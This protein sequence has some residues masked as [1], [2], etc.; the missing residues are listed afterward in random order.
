MQDYSARHDP[1]E[2]QVVRKWRIGM[3]AF[4]GSIVATLLLLSAIADRPVQLAGNTDR[5]TA[6]GASEHARS[7]S[8]PTIRP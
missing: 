5:P 1:E 8:S 2:R 6:V 7:Q 3:L 4:Y